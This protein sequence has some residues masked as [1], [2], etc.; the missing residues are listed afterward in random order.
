M[1][2]MI[3]LKGPLRFRSQDPNTEQT[4]NKLETVDTIVSKTPR[5]LTPFQRVKEGTG[6]FFLAA[7]VLPEPKKSN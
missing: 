4:E 1:A 6:E 7:G 5:Q 2:R 3:K